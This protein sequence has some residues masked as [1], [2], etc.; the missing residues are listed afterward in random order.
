MYGVIKTGSKYSTDYKAYI[1]KNNKVISPWHDINLFDGDLINVFNEIP[2][3]EN[4]KF[5]M[6]KNGDFNYIC[7]DIKNNKPRFVQN[8]FP[9]KGYLWNYGAIP[10]TWED[11]NEIDELCKAK[12]DN[13]PID[14]IEIGAKQ[15]KI[16]EV[17][18]AKVLGCLAMLDDGE[19]DWKIVVIDVNDEKAKLVHDIADVDKVFPNLLSQI[20]I[21]FKD[22]KIPS[23]KKENEFALDGKYL[24]KDEAMK[25]I[26]KT[27]ESYKNM[28]KKKIEGISMKSAK[29]NDQINVEKDE[30]KE[31]EIPSNLGGFYFIK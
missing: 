28:C 8:L 26:R 24:G 2:R 10:Q 16:G 31:S 4:A 12:G 5:E 3:F 18:K 1:T 14:V 17:Y 21:W 19:C 20:K 27:H 22:Y 13:D 9:F 29:N 6:S 25:I 15:K 30:Q 11:L 23:N 7:Q